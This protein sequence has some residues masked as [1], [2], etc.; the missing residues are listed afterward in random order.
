MS[1]TS[2]TSRLEVRTWKWGNL[3]SATH[4]NVLRAALERHL[5]LPHELVCI[6]DDAV[7]ID[8]RVRIVPMPQAFDHTPRCRRRMQGFDRDFLGG[9][10]VL[11]IDLDV[12]ILRN[13]TSIV[14][15]PEPIVCWR[16]G[17][18]GVFSG[19]FL[20]ADHGALHG[21]WERF[22]NDPDGYPRRLQPRGVASDQAM[23][24]DWLKSW[25][26]HTPFWTEA[27]GFVTFYGRGYEK[28]EHLGVGP[29][30]RQLPPGARIVVLG[31]ADLA[32][33]GDPSYPWV[34]E[35]WLS[36][37]EPAEVLS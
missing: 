25:H 31:S 36:L 14:N 26:P 1:I 20:L 17:H 23:L 24:N 3:F 5:D 7:G 34:A 35:H 21:A 2:G 8:G 18:A 27:D 28:L 29:N 10:R 9:G 32:V 15:R 22:R 4:V 12:V 11:Y 6:T 37:V 30:R 33:L 16:V 19:S 13:I